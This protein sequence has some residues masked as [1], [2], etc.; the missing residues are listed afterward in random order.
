MHTRRPLSGASAAP[1]TSEPQAHLFKAKALNP[2]RSRESV[3]LTRTPP[4]PY[5]GPGTQWVPHMPDR[6]GADGASQDVS[7]QDVLAPPHGQR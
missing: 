4:A 6:P 2:P 1:P 5:P 7:T 3:P